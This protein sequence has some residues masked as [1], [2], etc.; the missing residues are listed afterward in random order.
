MTGPLLYDIMRV[1]CPW[2]VLRAWCC[3]NHLG[4]LESVGD[5]TTLGALDL[6]ESHPIRN[7]LELRESSQF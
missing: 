7:H 1:S 2:D 4:L 3:R 5:K 6:G